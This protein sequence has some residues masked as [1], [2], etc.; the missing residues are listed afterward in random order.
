MAE[1]LWEVHRTKGGRLTGEVL[2]LVNEVRNSFSRL[3]ICKGWQ[4]DDKAH[5]VMLTEEGIIPKEAGIKILKALRQMEKEGVEK[6]KREIGGHSR[7]CLLGEL[8]VTR[9]LG[10]DIGGW[11]NCGRSGAEIGLVGW[12]V[13]ARDDII[14]ILKELA[15]IRRTFLEKAGE[16]IE[17]VMPGYTGLQQAETLTLGFYLLGWVHQF[18]RDSE[19]FQAAYKHTNISPAGCGILTATDY[20]INRERQQELLGFDSTF[21]NARDGLWSTD[22]FL[23]FLSAM[24]TTAGTLSKLADDLTIWQSSEFGMVEEPMAY[25]STSAIMPQKKNPSASCIRG[26]YGAIIGVLMSFLAIGKTHSDAFDTDSMG[27][28]LMFSGAPPKCLAALQLMNGIVKD[29]EVN[30]ELMKERAGMFWTQAVSLANAIVR[31][32]KIPFRTAHAI[33]GRLVRMAYDEGKKPQDTTS[34]MLDGAAKAYGAQPLYLNEGVLREALDPAI[35]VKSKKVLGGTAPER[36]RE[37]IARSLERVK[38]D[39]KVVATMESK[40]AAAE[41][42]LEEAVDKIIG[43][44]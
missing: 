7:G 26:L 38:E 14:A 29:L 13:E 43:E 9:V 27:L 42:R 33:V 20:P 19:R 34:E 5:T 25:S 12:R 18:E 21:T 3:I 24:V 6:V 44:A 37:D 39:E 32:K 41:R 35:I 28:G 22:Q 1:E 40:L 23:E 36:I 16:H 31:E 30:K 2:P 8:Y 17:T 15:N 10:P 4:M 11:I